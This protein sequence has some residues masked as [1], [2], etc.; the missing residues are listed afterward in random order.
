[1]EPHRDTQ[2]VKTPD[3][4]RLYFHTSGPAQGPAMVLCDGVGCDG[5]I[6]KYLLPQLSERFRVVRWHYRGHGRSTLP[7]DRA[8]LGMDTTCEDLGRVLDAT[9][10]DQ[11]VLFGHS[12]GTQ[13]ALQ[14]HQCHPRRVQGLVLVCGSFEY[15]LDT[16]HDGPLLKLAFPYL[17]A[18]VERYPGLAGAVVRTLMGTELAVEVGLWV[19]ANRQ[20]I[21]RM[22]FVPYFQHIA[23]M[24]VQCFVRTLGSLAEHSAR[25]H[26]PHV[27]APTL[28]L[29]GELDKFTPVRLSREMARLIPGAELAMLPGGTHTAPLEQPELVWRHVERFLNERVLTAPRVAKPKVAKKAARPPRRRGPEKR[30]PRTS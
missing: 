9:G 26:L 1:L 22:D 4:A 15:P 14:F 18:A 19:E 17:R 12:M 25:A 28:V 21:Q 2:Y 6:W 23:Q 27:D 20:L 8:T 3:G 16:F 29:G 10:I 24:D 7:D 5:F 11:A 30:P 13:V